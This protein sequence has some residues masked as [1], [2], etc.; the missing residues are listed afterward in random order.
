[1]SLPEYTGRV[2][3]ST[4]SSRASPMESAASPAPSRAASRAISS[5]CRVVTAP[6]IAGG[7]SLLASSAS[8]GIHTSPRYGENAAFSK[9]QTRLAPSSP[10]IFS[11]SGVALSVSHTASAWLPICPAR[12]VASPSTSA[13][14]FFG[15]PCRSSST[16]HQN[17]PAM[18]FGSPVLLDRFGVFAKRADQLLDGV[19]GLPGK[20][21]AGGARRQRLELHHGER[22]RLGRDAEIGRLDVL[23]LLLLRSH[24]AFQRGIA[25]L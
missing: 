17:A 9:S 4:P 13:I 7:G 12:R 3:T 23:D 25:R 14:T 21:P 19:R 5:R 22:G 10:S 16:M 20:D 8:T 11:P 15:L 24:D 6:R 2:A 1:M 18:E